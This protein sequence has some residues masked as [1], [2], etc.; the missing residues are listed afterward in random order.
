MK[1]VF[2]DGCITRSKW[3][4]LE[5]CMQLLGYSLVG[6]TPPLVT[7]TWTNCTKYNL[8]KWTIRWTENW[9][10][11]QAQRIIISGMK[12]SQRLNHYWGQYC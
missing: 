11:S 5:V 4:E 8:C 1:F 2:P 3:E 7:S 9:L 6:M 12:S 10:N